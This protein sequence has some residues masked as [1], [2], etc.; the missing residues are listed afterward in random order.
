MPKKLTY[1]E[2]EQRVQELEKEVPK[3]KKAEESLEKR[4]KY[5]RMLRKVS[6]RAALIENTKKFQDESLEV[7]GEALDIDRAYIFEHN[8]KNDTTDN[9]FEWCAPDI[10]PQKDELQDI[11]SNDIRWWIDSLRKNEIIRYKDIED[12]PSEQVKEILRPQNI[13][14]IL[15]VPLF[16]KDRYFGFIGFDE[17]R[18]YRD[19]LDED[20]DILKTTSQIIIGVIER[21]RVEEDREGLINELQ[22]ALDNI[23]TLSG[24]LPICASCK[25]IRDDKGYWNQIEGYIEKHSDAQLSHGLCPDCMDKLYGDE[26]WY[27]K[28]DFDK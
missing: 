28:E 11:P 14:S 19:W 17:C 23:K 2:L 4:L 24:L 9:I 15:V 8:Y 22:T 7:I 3:R 6:E 13:K 20:V 10:R 27:K 16:E 12:I 25:K 5:E 1:E 18:H 21:K 26:D